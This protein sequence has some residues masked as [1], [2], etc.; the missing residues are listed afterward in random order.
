MRACDGSIDHV[1]LEE[2]QI[3]FSTIGGGEPRGICGSG[4]IDAV[5]VFLENG[6]INARGR[7]APGCEIDGERVLHITEAI[8]LT[9]ED[10]RQVQLA[11]GA[12]RAGIELMAREM[13]VSMADIDKFLLAGA[14][15]SYISPESACKI[16]L[17]PPA[18]LPKIHPIG[19]AAAQGANLIAANPRMLRLTDLLVKN[20]E[21]LEL[22]SLGE[23]SKAFAAAMRF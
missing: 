3:R 4:L 18:L 13:G 5:A 23:F 1:W 7:V 6:N 16:G 11:K 12:I 20:S 9:Q 2:G 14:F 10:I 15:G 17:L 22:A 8:Y 21:Y 19:N